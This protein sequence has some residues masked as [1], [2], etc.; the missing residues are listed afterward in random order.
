MINLIVNFKR[1][2]CKPYQP[3]KYVTTHISCVIMYN[4]VVLMELFSISN[5]NIIKRIFKLLA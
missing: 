5:K 1:Q 3:G 2:E 4:Y